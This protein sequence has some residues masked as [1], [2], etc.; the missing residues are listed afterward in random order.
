MELIQIISKILVYG[1]SA[2][3]VV[4]A[5]SF[6]IARKKKDKI[7]NS[8]NNVPSI[9]VYNRNSFAANNEQIVQRRNSTVNVPIVYPIDPRINRDVKILRKP[10]VTK[11]EIQER[12]KQEENSFKRTNGTKKRYTI[13]ND[14]LKKSSNFNVINL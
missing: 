12:I 6:L 9:V 10:T 8:I 7:K 3:I 11:K 4:I 5:L 2:L 1:G 14:E 13:V